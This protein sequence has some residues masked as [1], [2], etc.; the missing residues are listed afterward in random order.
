MHSLNSFDLVNYISLISYRINIAC[1]NMIFILKI[2]NEI[3]EDVNYKMKLI[4]ETV[5]KIDPSYVNTKS[6]STQHL[7]DLKEII[8]L[9]GD[10]E[11]IFIK[12]TKYKSTHI[13][14]AT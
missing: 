9:I 7:K 11:L 6:I 13:F 4:H 2:G 1:N 3:C 8:D 5:A 14:C 12:K 10:L